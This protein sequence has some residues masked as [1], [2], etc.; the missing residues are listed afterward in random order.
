MPSFDTIALAVIAF[1][2]IR[3]AVRFLAPAR[4]TQNT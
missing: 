4:G 2:A 1:V 3:E